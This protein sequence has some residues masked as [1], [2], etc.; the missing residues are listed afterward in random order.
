[1]IHHLFLVVSSDKPWSFRFYNSKNGPAGGSTFNL[2]RS[3]ARMMSNFSK[4]KKISAIE[5]PVNVR[6]LGR[7][8]CSSYLSGPQMLLSPSEYFPCPLGEKRR[9]RRH[10]HCPAARELQ[11]HT[12]S[13]HLW[14]STFMTVFEMTKSGTLRNEDFVVLIHSSCLKF[15]LLLWGE[16]PSW[17]GFTWII[18]ALSRRVA[19][20]MP[21]NGRDPSTPDKIINEWRL[22]ALIKN[23]LE[24]SPNVVLESLR[25]HAALVR[26]RK[27]KGGK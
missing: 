7:R 9:W 21:P 24:Q 27:Q 14:K 23:R 25:T 17:I 26:R 18:E 8:L 11:K 20:F 12:Q 3:R 6:S 10:R 16:V 1:M 13:W 22:T 5:F 19:T 2:T 15:Y 4:K